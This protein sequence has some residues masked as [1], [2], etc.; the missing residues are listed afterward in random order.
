MSL[1]ESVK[2]E[3]DMKGKRKS[4]RM[5]FLALIV[6]AVPLAL[7]GIISFVVLQLVAGGKMS[8]SAGAMCL[9][10]SLMIVLIV[11]FFMVRQLLRRIQNLLGSLDEI[12]DGTLSMKD[13]KLSQRNDEIGQVMRS[14]NG[15]FV[16][17]AEMVTSMKVATESLVKVPDDVSYSL[18]DMESSIRQVGKEAN[19]ISINA[20][21]Q[22]EK[23]YEAGTQIID[24]GQAVDAIAQDVEMLVRGS[25]KMKAC[26]EMAQGVMEELVSANESGSRAVADVRRQADVT[27]RSAAQIRDFSEIIADFSGR[28]NLLALNASI[29]AARAGELGKGFADVA[30]QIR[31]LADQSRESSKQMDAIVSELLGSSE[32]G[33]VFARKAKEAS[34]RQAEKTSQAEGIILSLKR[35]IEQMGGVIGGIGREVKELEDRKEFSISSLHE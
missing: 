34:E 26:S 16:S 22:S 11:V 27:S 7:T 24:M 25:D 15:M 35:D 20:V 3:D 30:E 29:E 33:V 21:S 6:L 2:G 23:V 8:V 32:A 4:R 18:R 13:D 10:F 1:D 9:V 28:D 14:V 5:L 31:S 17:F 12:A 19:S